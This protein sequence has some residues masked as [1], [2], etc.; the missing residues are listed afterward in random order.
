MARRKGSTNVGNALR[1]R[2]VA[3]DQSFASVKPPVSRAEYV[4]SVLK[5]EI[6]SGALPPGTP[7]LQEEISARLGVSVT[8]VREALRKL[9]SLGLLVYKTHGGA[10]VV[11]LS[12]N[13]IEELYALRATVE[14]LAARLAADSI[15]DAE[16]DRLRGIHQQMKDAHA[17]HDAQALAAK[18][19]LFHSA[20]AE[21]G[22]RTIIARHLG[23]IWEGHP[24][25]LNQSVWS[26]PAVATEAIE[27][28]EQIIRALEGRDKGLAERLMREHVELAVSHRLATSAR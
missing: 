3:T 11:E 12:Q 2:L 27:Y 28:H 10:T 18:S 22:G 6:L 15:T 21:A 20:V 26:D 14:G 7:I 17:A 13:E 16:F 19:R 25:P 8:P 24:I 1:D 9:E 5:A 4:Q 23:L